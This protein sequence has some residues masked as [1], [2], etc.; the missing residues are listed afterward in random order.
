[1][2]LATLDFF[3]YPELFQPA[4]NHYRTVFGWQEEME[5]V[6]CWHAWQN[7]SVYA[8]S[9]RMNN[10]LNFSV[11]W[12]VMILRDIES[13]FGK[14]KFHQNCNFNLPAKDAITI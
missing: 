5:M 7:F 2:L 8:F 13:V 3:V 11:L 12:G 1:M 14:T 4:E 6:E 9:R 10:S